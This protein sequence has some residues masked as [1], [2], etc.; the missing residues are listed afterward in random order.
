MGNKKYIFLN[1]NKI[2]EA[3]DA[4]WTYINKYYDPPAFT[5]LVDWKRDAQR[6][7][8]LCLNNFQL[9]QSLPLINAVGKWKDRIMY[10][11][12]MVYKPSLLQ[13]I[14]IQLNYERFGEP[15][16]SFTDIFLTIN[17]QFRPEGW[18]PPDVSNYQPPT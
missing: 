18:A 9:E 12:L 10:E 1:R 16:V 11:Y 15:P 3:L 13:G 6:S 14:P 7:I 4:A 5:Q 17:Y 2:D 8:D